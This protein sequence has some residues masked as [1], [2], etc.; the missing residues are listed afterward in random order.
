MQT[1]ILELIY[2]FNRY[3]SIPRNIIIY[4][5]SLDLFYCLLSFTLKNSCGIFTFVVKYVCRIL[6]VKGTFHPNKYKFCH[7]FLTLM[8]FKT[9]QKQKKVF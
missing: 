6:R 9:R 7:H 1:F 8:S 4:E 3:V 5:K 2:I